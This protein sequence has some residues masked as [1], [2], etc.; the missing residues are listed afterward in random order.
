V[1]RGRAPY[2]VFTSH[3]WL[4]RAT[5]SGDVVTIS[6]LS[7]GSGHYA[8]CV[9]DDTVVTISVIDATQAIAAIRVTIQDNGL[10]CPR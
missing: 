1:L 2:Q 7:D 10:V 3:P 8:P 6:T 9:E 5:V 4:L